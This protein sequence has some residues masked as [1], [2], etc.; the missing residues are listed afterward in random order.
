MT[1]TLKKNDTPKLDGIGK[2]LRYYVRALVSVLVVVSFRFKKMSNTLNRW[3]NFVFFYSDIKWSFFSFHKHITSIIKLDSNF[4]FLNK[5]QV[6]EKF[7]YDMSNAE[8]LG[9]VM[10]TDFTEMHVQY[11]NTRWI[12]KMFRIR[13]WKRNVYLKKML[14]YGMKEK[15]NFISS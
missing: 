15:C 13:S 1:T 8:L 11:Y 3:N 5:I 6:S 14:Y 7:Y 2:L 9:Y 10:F 12:S 4:F